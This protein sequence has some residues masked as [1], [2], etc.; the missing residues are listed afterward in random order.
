M[1]RSSA[2][3]KISDKIELIENFLNLAD[4]IL[5]GGA[6]AY[7]FLRAKGVE[8]GNRWWKPTRS[9]RAKNCLPSREKR[10]F[11]RAAGGSRCRV[12][13]GQL[14]IRRCVPIDR[15]AAGSHGTGYWSRNDPPV[16]AKSSRKPR[17][18]SGTDRWAS[19]RTLDFAKGRLRSPERSPIRSAFSIVGGGDS[20]AAVAQSGVE[21][22]ITHI[23]TGGGASLD[24]FR[25]G[26]CR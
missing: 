8:T 22:K 6:M 11:D 15:H 7:T 4:T 9:S 21:S 18:L 19:S 10:S 12:R 20:A 5:I 14:G 17:P 16:F 3:R 26:S 25:D 13:S 24:F 2:G 1:L 23:S